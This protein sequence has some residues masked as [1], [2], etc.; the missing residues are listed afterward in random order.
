MPVRLYFCSD[1]GVPRS[2]YDPLGDPLGLGVL[3]SCPTDLQILLSRTWG[4]GWPVRIEEGRRA[5][6]RCRGFLKFREARDALHW[7]TG[8]PKLY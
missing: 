1:R 5:G 3:L 4:S 7:G 6:A 2:L 8:V